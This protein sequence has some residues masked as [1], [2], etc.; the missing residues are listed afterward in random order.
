MSVAEHT[1]KKPG[2]WSCQVVRE[3]VISDFREFRFTWNGFFRWTGITAL[4]RYL[5]GLR[6]DQEPPAAR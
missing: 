4:Y 5:A 2:K 6:T 1:E 3:R